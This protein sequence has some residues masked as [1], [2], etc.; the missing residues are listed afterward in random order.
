MHFPLIA[1]R[2]TIENHFLSLGAPKAHQKCTSCHD[3]VS[4]CIAAA[5]HQSPLAEHY[6][7]ATKATGQQKFPSTPIPCIRLRMGFVFCTTLSPRATT[8]LSHFAGANPCVLYQQ[9][10]NDMFSRGQH[11]FVVRNRSICICILIDIFNNA[12]CQQGI[13]RVQPRGYAAT[14]TFPQQPHI[15]ARHVTIT[16]MP[17]SLE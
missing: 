16:Y 4:K 13:P 3:W 1:A 12:R 9:Q 6:V 14:T 10:I 8:L 5:M 11:R 7:Y 15:V 17:C 2:W